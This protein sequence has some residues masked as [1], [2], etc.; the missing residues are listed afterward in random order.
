MSASRSRRQ[1]FSVSPSLACPEC[2]TSRPVS[3]CYYWAFSMCAK[4][5]PSSLKNR[6]LSSNLV[7]SIPEILV[8]DFVHPQYSQYLPQALVYK[9][10]DPYQCGIVHSPRS[11]SVWQHRLDICV[12]QTDFRCFA[13]YP[14]H[15]HVSQN[16]KCFPCFAD[17][18]LYVSLCHSS[19]PL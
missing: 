12:E 19:C 17:S 10:L 5:S 16:V 8:A 14:G 2:S 7:C 18:C 9:S 1:V 3:Y 6:Y 4:P 13:D 15:P 11:C